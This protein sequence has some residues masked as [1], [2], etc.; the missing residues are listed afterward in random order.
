MSRLQERIGEPEPVAEHGLEQ[1]GHDNEGG[2]LRKEERR[3][4]EPS[5]TQSR[6]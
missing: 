3:L 5:C 6:L 1:D 4:E 2:D